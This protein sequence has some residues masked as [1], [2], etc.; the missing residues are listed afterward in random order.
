MEKEHKIYELWL[1][2][3]SGNSEHLAEL[4]GIADNAEELKDRFYRGLE[5]GTAGLR[6]VL[7]MG[8]NRMNVYTVRQA[9]Q[10]LSEFLL[11]STAYPSVA[12]AYD[13]RNLSDTFARET[14]CVFA[15][16]GIKVYIYQELMPTPALSYA[17][18]EYGCDAGVVITASHNPANYNGYKAYGGDGCQ[19]GPEQAGRVMRHISGIDIF[20]EVKSI[21]FEEAIKQGTVAY[22]PESFVQQYLNRVYEEAIQAEV[23]AKAGLKLVYTPLN[24]AGNRCVREVLQKAGIADIAVVPEQEHPDGNFP[25]CP[26]PNP[27]IKETLALGLRLCEKLGADM[28]LATDPDADRVAVA[29]KGENGG[30]RILSGNEAGVLLL[31]YIANARRAKGTLPQNPIAVKSI[32]T[33]KLADRVAEANGIEMRNVLTGFKY[34]GEVILGLEQ[35]G[36]ESRFVLGFEESCGYLTGSYV[37]DKDAVNAALLLVEMAS[38]HKLV[39]KS[40]L[41][42]LDEIY[43]EYGIYQNLV[44]SFTFEGADGMRQM[45]DI[46]TSIRYTPPKEIAGCAVTSH[47]D[48]LVGKRIK[49][50]TES[51]TGLPAS[52]VLEYELADG[53]SAI[54]RPSGTEPKIKIY[55]SLVADTSETIEALKKKY[56][57]AGKKLVL[58]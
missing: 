15:A 38:A 23:C 43:G 13:S 42:R 45:A 27:E 9:T 1:K 24:G 2:K 58:G 11:E 49:G 6:G 8:T 30:Y 31:D 55:Y 16:N 57:A 17:V 26:Y 54:I 5:F 56:S 12:I 7:G 37:R 3:A 25:T 50:E 46:M 40:P 51:E 36:E 10:G 32:V 47:T 18:R 21:A 39:G 28:L 19:L 20:D 35:K 22:I 44:E 4:K 33:S 52:D 34:I 53:C 14:A 41:E 48:Y 29:V